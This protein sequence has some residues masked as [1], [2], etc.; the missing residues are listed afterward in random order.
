MEPQSHAAGFESFAG[1][2]L[3][4]RFG[5]RR[6]DAALVLLNDLDLGY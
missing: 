1:Y 2:V 5:V 4:V 3:N 6:L